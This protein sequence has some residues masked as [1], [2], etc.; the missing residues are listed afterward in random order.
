[1]LINLNAIIREL[2]VL[3]NISIDELCEHLATLGFPVDEVRT[4]DD[5]IVIDVDVTSNRGDAQSHRGIARDLATKLGAT[6]SPLPQ[7]VVVEGRPLISVQLE[8]PD[9][10]PV[11]CAALLDIDPA[12]NNAVPE[13]TEGF[14]TSMNVGVKKLLAVDASN[15]ILHLYGQP[16]HAFDAD[17]VHGDVSVRWARDGESIVTI[18]LVERSLTSKDL[19][20]ADSVGPIAMAGLIGGNSTKV[21]DNTRR[22]LLESAFFDSRTVQAMSYR[23]NLHTDASQRFGRGVDPEFV[24]LARNLFIK[25]LQ[26]WAGASLQSA[27]TVGSIPL[28]TDC[29]S[30]PWNL[31]NRVAGHTIDHGNVA[32]L[33]QN[34][35]CVICHQSSDGLVVKVPSWRYDLKIAVD[36]VEEVL[37]LKGYET[38][39]SEIPQLD[40]VP[41]PLASDY[42]KRRHLTSRLANLGFFQTVTMG[43]GSPEYSDNSEENSDDCLDFKTIQNPLSEQ[44]SVMRGSLLP[45]L[46]RVAKLNLERGVK[47]ARYF[48]IAPIFKNDD[49]SIKEIWTLGVVWGGVS[50]GNDPLSEVCDISKAEGQS[51]L[52]GILKSIGVPDDSIKSFNNWQMLDHKG[53][54]RGRLGWHFEIPLSLISNKDES[55]IPKF[56]PFSRFP[57]M[58]RDLSLLVDLN[59]SYNSL[60]NTMVIAMNSIGAP[61]HDL[62][63]I[64]VF[65]HKSLPY[66]HQAWLFRLCFQAMDHTLTK[67]EVDS[68]MDLALT[69]AESCGARL[70]G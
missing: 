4:L 47:E 44:Y 57:V 50:G 45:D 63:C 14:L 9:V 7:V 68:W 66:G 65:R 51:Y 21:S 54:L 3:K 28:V 19:I 26:D 24:I 49:K 61:L 25:R 33:L 35:G 52:I 11:Y 70:R 67:E 37:R 10:A 2:P 34:L 56:V 18:D 5:N 16:T 55:V 15:E 12:A 8:D 20:I 6:L 22:L 64:D 60:R 1:M 59:Q 42:M 38:I 58:E 48:E 23:H 46:V 29:I 53:G 39:S 17:L 30:L 40:S 41:V 69:A 43:F 31:L 32:L 27:W 62:R 36:L 13:A